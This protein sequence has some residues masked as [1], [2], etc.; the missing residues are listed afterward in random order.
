MKEQGVGS[1]SLAHNTLEEYKGMLEL[2][3]G[4][5]KNDKHQLLTR[6]YTKPR[7]GG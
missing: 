2:Q 6:T 7:Q 3:D 5:S 1:R 4:T